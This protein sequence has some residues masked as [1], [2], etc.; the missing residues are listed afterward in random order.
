MLKKIL[1]HPLLWIFFLAFFLRVWHLDRYPYGFHVD[2]VKV[3]WNAYSLFKTGRDDWWHAFPLHYD[4]FGDQ[5]PTGIIYTVVPSIALFDLNQFAVRFPSALFGSFGVI[6]V[7]FLCLQLSAM[8]YKLSALSALLAAISPWHIS[9]S[10]ATSEGIISSTL[11]LFGLVYLLKKRPNL[12]VS[13]VLLILSYFFY[14]SARLLVPIFVTAAIF[15]QFFTTKKY[16]FS[17]ILLLAISY[18]LSAIFFLSPIARSRL[19]QVSIFNDFTVRD[20]ID[21]LPFEE[22]Q[23]KVITARVFHNKLVLYST[24]FLDEYFQYFSPKF[25]LSYTEAKPMRYA[26]VMRSPLLYIEFLLLVF[27]LLQISKAKATGYKLLAVLLLIAPIPAGFTNEDSPNM[28]RALLMSPFI[29]VITAIGL[30]QIYKYQKIIFSVTLLLLSLDFIYFSHQ[31]LIHNPARDQLTIVRNGGVMELITELDRISPRYK[32]IFM[33]NRPDPLYTWFAFYHKLNPFTFNQILA[34]QKN[35]D[36]TYQN[37]TFSQ[38][39][40]PSETLAEGQ[41]RDTL[42]VNAEGCNQ[43]PHTDLVAQIPRLGGGISYTLWVY[44]P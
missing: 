39:R 37:I 18:S 26:T 21:R 2:E 20:S 16:N 24:R 43:F 32:Q 12:I 11:I 10:R 40:C 1:T 13:A 8:N 22:G 15:W 17:A 14:H 6:A 7:Y 33:T 36:F 44:K 5:R 9:L 29:S 19:N 25:F 31:Y 23:N 42:A 41:L 28:H 35:I 30:A 34:G 4:S 38:H 3:G 27:G